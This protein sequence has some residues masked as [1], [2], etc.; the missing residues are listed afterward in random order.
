MIQVQVSTLLMIRIYFF[1]FCERG[2]I[3]KYYRVDGDKSSDI[4]DIGTLQIKVKDD[5]IIGVTAYYAPGQDA[6]ILSAG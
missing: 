2:D 6:T 3:R 4:A 5:K 1:D